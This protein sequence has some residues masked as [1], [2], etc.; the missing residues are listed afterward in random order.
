[1]DEGYLKTHP[2]L[3]KV[4]TFLEKRDLATAALVCKQWHTVSNDPYLWVNL[5]LKEVNDWYTM[6]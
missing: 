1:M 5:D 2:F 4:F 6:H 3:L